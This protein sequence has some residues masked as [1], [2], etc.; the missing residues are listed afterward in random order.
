M[1]AAEKQSGD[2]LDAAVDAGPG[3]SA[4]TVVPADVAG[5]VADAITARLEADHAVDRESHALC[6]A[7]AAMAQAMKAG[8]DLARTAVTEGVAMALVA[9]GIPR[10][11][12]NLAGRAA[13]DTLMR[14]TSVRHWED[15]RRAVELLAVPI[16]PNVTDHP[17]VEQ[18]CLQPLTSEIL[19]S[20][21]QEEWLDSLPGERQ[22]PTG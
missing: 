3:T 19:S 11:A 10:L 14:L 1:Q 13:A 6:G 22:L 17:K 16:C 21:I 20:A 5:Q 9:A 15:V 2:L 12:A 4:A 18:Y 7:L 8:E